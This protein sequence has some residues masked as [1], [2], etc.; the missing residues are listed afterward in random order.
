M[1]PNDLLNSLKALISAR[2]AETLNTLKALISAQNAEMGGPADRVFT[3]EDERGTVI[4]DNYDRGAVALIVTAGGRVI[5]HD[6][7]TGMGY[8]ISEA[9]ARGLARCFFTTAGDRLVIKI[10]GNLVDGIAY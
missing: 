2:S 8:Y 9:D 7:V 3:Y 10:T 4:A 5:A 6:C 1:I